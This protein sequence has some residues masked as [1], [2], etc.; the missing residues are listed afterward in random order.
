LGKGEGKGAAVGICIDCIAKRWNRACHPV[1]NGDR[2][3][4]TTQTMRKYVPIFERITYSRHAEQRMHRRHIRR[5]LVE[6]VLRIGEGMFDD[7][8]QTWTYTLDPVSV[9]IVERDDA[10]HVVTVIRLRREA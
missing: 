7:E 9:V 5:D 4:L 1:E 6:L 8:E 3:R 2:A 10:A